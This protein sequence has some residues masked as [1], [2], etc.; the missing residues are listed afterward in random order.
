MRAVRWALVAWAVLVVAGAGALGLLWHHNR[1]ADDLAAD[2]TAAVTTARSSVTT[3]LTYDGRTLA[4]RLDKDQTL[5]AP[6]F[7]ADYRALVQR[8]VLPTAR[9]DGVRAQTSVADA[10][11]VSG[12]DDRAQVLLYLDVH[13]TTSA[14]GQGS[15]QGGRLLV[16]MTREEGQWLVSGLRSL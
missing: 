15:T 13:T 2:R 3:L 6:A 14:S 8:S 5:L 11:L 16:T 9:K 4:T 7:R 10:A 12:S 1:E